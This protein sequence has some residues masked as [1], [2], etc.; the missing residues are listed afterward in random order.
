MSGGQDRRRFLRA[1]GLGCVAGSGM[2]G[3]SPSWATATAPADLRR[4]LLE[5][6][7]PRLL[8][9]R[10]AQTVAGTGDPP[11]YRL[12]DCST[13]RNLGP[14]G[15]DQ[16]RALAAMVQA[17]GLRFDEVRSSRWCRCLETARLAFGQAEGWPPLDSFFDARERGPAQLARLRAALQTLRPG[18]LSAWV[19]HQV[20]MTGLTGVWPASGEVL[21]IEPRPDAQPPVIIARFVPA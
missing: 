8:L 10:H 19:T 1:T 13:Q 9:M 4:W 15:R 21:I 20:V 18:S 3:P 2:L 16:A 6:E 14:D 5:G 7:R 17:A 11:G 12:D